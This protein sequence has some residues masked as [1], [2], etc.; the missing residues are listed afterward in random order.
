MEFDLISRQ[1]IRELCMDARIPVSRLAA[2]IGRS[3]STV[4][5]RIRFVEKRAGLRYIVEPDLV[6]LGLD[7]TYYVAIRLRRPLPDKEV[8]SLLS[9][10]PIPQFA[11]SCRGEF[12]LLLF[13]AARNQLE[14]MRWA[15]VFRS[16]LSE[17]IVSWKASHQVFARH[18]F[19][20]VNDRILA[21]SSLLS[22][23]KELLIELNRD[24][25]LSFRELAKRIGTTVARVRYHFKLLL[26]TG[27]V[28]RFTAVMQKPAKPVN[29][30]HF[31]YYTYQKE[32][33][34]QSK[35]DRILI[36]T[37]EPVQVPNTY[38]FVVETSGASDGFD[39][40]CSDD[41]KGAYAGLHA[42]ERLYHGY[43]RTESAVVT[44]VIYGL[45]PVRSMDLEKT[46]DTSSWE[47]E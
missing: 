35:R 13:V 20:P 9:Q 15:F 24:S 14:Y 4:I 12:D 1:V 19:F 47:Q 26:R 8:A 45:W 23:Q 18:G 29:L 40:T 6:K 16:A 43:L 44:K 37:E 7:F 2:K 36:K 5:S 21:Q 10:S 30:V 17:E 3:R 25:K 41:T 39:W 28:K 22:P 34:E 38:Q 31:R 46:Y 32:H 11:A 33:E 27:C 42:A